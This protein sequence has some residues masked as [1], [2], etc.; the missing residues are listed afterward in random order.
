[1]IRHLV[2]FEFFQDI[3]K[4]KSSESVKEEQIYQKSLEFFDEDLKSS[5]ESVSNEEI[6]TGSEK[7]LEPLNVFDIILIMLQQLP[8]RKKPIGSLLSK[9]ILMNFMNWMQ[10]KQ[11]IME[12]QMTEYY[13]KK[14]GLACVKEPKNEEYLLQIFKISKEFVIDLR[15]SK[16]QEYLENQKFKEAAEIVMKHEVVDDYSFEQITLPLILCD[17][18]QIVDELLKISKKLQKSYISF[19]DQFVAE[20]DETVNAFFEPYKEKGMVTINL[21]RF[22]GKSLT[23]FMQKFFNGQVKQFKFDLEE[24]RDAPKFVANMKRKALKYFVGKRF[25]DHEMNDELFCEHMKSTLPECTDKTIVQ[26]LILLWDTCI[27]ERRLVFFKCT[28]IF[29]KKYIFS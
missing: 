26:F 21:S 19:L 27:Y 15:K 14:A 8:E 25:E 7:E 20:T 16:V 10:D 4:S 9:W 2:L 1:M 18:V 28:K 12:Q 22:H 24:R 5:E 23:I 6:K 13:Q 11:S 3:V 17:K 29:N